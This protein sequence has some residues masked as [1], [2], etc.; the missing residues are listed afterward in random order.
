MSKLKILIVG[1]SIAGPTAAYFFAK[2][3]ATVTIIERFPHLRINGQNVD[4][5]TSGVTVMRKIPGMEA[6][7]RANTFDLDGLCLVRENGKPYGTIKTSGSP[8][9]QSLLSEYEIFRGRLAAILYDF[10]K[11]NE[12]IRYHF[13]EQVASIQQEDGIRAVK[14]TFLNGLQPA[15]YDLVVA[16]DGATSRTR[17]IG[18][19]C[20]VRDHI[21]PTNC[22]SAYFSTKQDLI[23]GSRLGHGFSSIPGRFM[24]VEYNSSGGNIVNMTMLHPQ[25]AHNATAA[26]RE[27]IAQG[28]DSLKQYLVSRFYNHGWKTK[29]V[30]DELLK[31]DDLY[32]SEVVQVKVPSL[33]N[34][35][36][37]LVGDAGYAPG[38]TGTG[39]T[40]ALTGAYIL[41]GEICRHKGDVKAGL[42]S[43]ENTM[44]P[45]INE[46][47]KVPPFVPSIL[48]PQTALAL[49]LRNNLFALLAWSKLL[50]YVQ[51][52]FGSSGGK[53]S[54]YPLPDYHWEND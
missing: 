29:E 11:N 27:A 54:E 41:A 5:R 12:N 31:T 1:A 18:F 48:A 14:V 9:Q 43:Y 7:V 42:A 17:A 22:W 13:E 23:H 37:A 26:L 28:D 52:F 35:R 47:S 8:D 50:E 51:R 2:A 34:G 15:E 45:I 25:S 44:R 36:F 19:H 4:I 21:F 38:F 3:G 40:L 6:A 49:W 16:C 10:T 32:A 33:F 30:L 53:T 20:G 39:T 24:S 46:M